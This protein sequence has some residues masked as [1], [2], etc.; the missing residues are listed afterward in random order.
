[1]V[2][3][4]QLR[5]GGEAAAAVRA[6][7][8]LLRHTGVSAAAL[9]D[10]SLRADVNVSVRQRAPGGVTGGRTEVKNL[11]STR[12][13]ARAVA[14]EAARHVALLSSGRPV[15]RQTLSFDAASGKTVP[16]RDKELATDYRFMPEPDVP[17]IVL[18]DA[19]LDAVRATLPELPGAAHAR[20]SRAHG[21]LPP[22]AAAALAAHPDTLAYFEQ[23]LAAG[24]AL[25]TAAG[26]DTKPVDART[27]ANWVTHE[28]VGAAREA[29][30]S[31]LRPPPSASPARL[32][33]LLALVAA[34]TL[35]GR[36]AKTV[37]AAMLR[38]DGRAVDALAADLCGGARVSDDATLRAMCA[39]VL[40][41]HPK[42]VRR[43]ALRGLRVREGGTVGDHARVLCRRW[44]NTRRAATA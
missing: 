34:G 11:N 40:Q 43:W 30:V 21:D 28:L 16:M 27:V 12:A 36:M 14:Y 29:G 20:L 24:E 17:E 15:P 9:E 2:T 35:S 8:R 7:Q 25:A 5:S 39:D 19:F 18:S 44:R 13:V 4:P 32:A 37:F 10:G 31:A 38:G 33:E 6:L 41:Q 26:G 23:A 3:A 42:Q 22:G 1:V